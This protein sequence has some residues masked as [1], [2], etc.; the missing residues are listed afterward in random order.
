METS[1]ARN[2]RLS[3]GFFRYCTGKIL[4]VGCGDDPIFKSVEKWDIELGNGDATFMDGV[5]D[6]S[7]DTVH[8]SHC[9]EHLLDP[10]TALKNWF[11]ILKPGG[12]LIL[13][14]PH[15]ELY[16]KRKTLPSRWNPD[17]K[18]FILPDEDDPPHTWSLVGLLDKTDVDYKLI[19]LQV[20]D[21]DH[22]ITDPN[23]HSDGEYST[24]CICKKI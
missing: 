5:D 13:L 24:E 17:H 16:E 15:R 1:K 2:R 21:A 23:I 12:Y 6:Q 10:V 22:T 9:L 20:C 8:S 4:D 19:K 18:F 14:T 7:Y 3:E 11:R